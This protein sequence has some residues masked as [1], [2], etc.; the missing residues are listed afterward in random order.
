MDEMKSVV[1]QFV[2]FINTQDLEGLASLTADQF[3]F[4]D[5]SGRVHQWNREGAVQECWLGYFKPFPEYQIHVQQVLTGGEG[6]A[7]IGQTSGSH[8]SAEIEARSTVLWV[9][10]LQ[11]GL[12]SDWRIYA[13]DEYRYG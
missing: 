9:A 1:L 2:E 6:V 7:I 5:S 3:I 12:V 10:G 8:V 11:D 4:T 13:T